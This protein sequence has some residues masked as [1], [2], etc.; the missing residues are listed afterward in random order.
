MIRIKR[1]NLLVGVGLDKLNV[2][3]SPCGSGFTRET[4]ENPVA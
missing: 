3:Q 2:A 1:R 4:V